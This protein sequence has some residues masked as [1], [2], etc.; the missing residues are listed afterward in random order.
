MQN[1]YMSMNAPAAPMMATPQMSHQQFAQANMTTF[2]AFGAKPA[3]APA[4]KESGVKD[5]VKKYWFPVAVAGFVGYKTYQD[6]KNTP[7]PTPSV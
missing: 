3:P 6:N 7:A 4:K 2:A 1:K 5:K